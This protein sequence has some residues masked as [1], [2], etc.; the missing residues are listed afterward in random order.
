[1]D[2][3]TSLTQHDQRQLDAL[4]YRV[5]E[6]VARLDG[7]GIGVD[8]NTSRNLTVDQEAELARLTSAGIPDSAIVAARTEMLRVNAL[9]PYTPFSRVDP[10]YVPVV[11]TLTADQEAGLAGLK[12]L[13]L[14]DDVIA[15]ARAELLK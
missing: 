2:N 13:G 14:P 8:V 3:P 7:A 15:Q 12:S 11:K 4:N 9:K 10:G 5:D 6:L 1:M